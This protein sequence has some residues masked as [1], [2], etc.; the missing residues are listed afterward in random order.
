[1]GRA[2]GSVC[3]CVCE[4]SCVCPRECACVHVL[5]AQLW[6]A[7]EQRWV[8]ALLRTKARPGTGP[9]RWSSVFSD[10]RLYWRVV[11]VGRFKGNLTK[12][13]TTLVHFS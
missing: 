9:W 11:S 13:G 4:S 12:E 3:V 5:S 2:C 7:P 8:F 6:L 1:M 10:S